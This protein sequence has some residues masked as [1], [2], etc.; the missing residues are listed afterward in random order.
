MY[1]KTTRFGSAPQ[2]V[3]RKGRDKTPFA[4]MGVRSSGRTLHV[5]RV[6]ETIEIYPQINSYV[7][8][9]DAYFTVKPHFLA[10]AGRLYQCVLRVSGEGRALPV[11][12]KPPA[13]LVVEI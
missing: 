12:E 9:R 11:K 13:K 8:N 4:I 3:K 7:E 6:C 2:E 1:S 5:G 10:A